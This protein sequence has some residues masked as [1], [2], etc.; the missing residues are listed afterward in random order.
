MHITG[1]LKDQNGTTYYKVKNSWGKNP[2]RTANDGYVYMSESYMK[3]KTI[4]VMVH[5]DAVP[6]TVKEKFSSL[7]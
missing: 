3:L 4:S 6:N 1:I 2:E 7:N 5:K